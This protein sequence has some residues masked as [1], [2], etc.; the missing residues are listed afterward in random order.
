MI[1]MCVLGI[2]YQSNVFKIIYI[3]ISFAFCRTS[4][5]IAHIVLPGAGPTNDISIEFEIRPK[6]AVLW[7]KMYC[8]NHNDILRT[9]RQCNCRNMCK[10]S[11]W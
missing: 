4:S 10:I 9:P 2:E 6:Y 11:L 7:F 8:T 5:Q 3:Y 1:T